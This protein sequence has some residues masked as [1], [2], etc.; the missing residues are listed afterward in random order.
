MSADSHGR[1]LRAAQR[2]VG[3]AGGRESLKAIL[4]MIEEEQK[5]AVR[6]VTALALQLAGTDKL[7]LR[8]R[9]PPPRPVRAVV[10]TE[11]PE[12]PSA[13][14]P[15]AKPRWTMDHR[16]GPHDLLTW[17]EA[18]QVPWYDPLKEEES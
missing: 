10:V 11:P 8:E 18:M 5:Q 1:F 3:K 7:P 2:M 15:A 9:P 13:P 6:A 4:L 14:P 17:E 12:R 16:P